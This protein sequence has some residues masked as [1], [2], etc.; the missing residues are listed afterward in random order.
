MPVLAF[1]FGVVLYLALAAARAFVIFVAVPLL[2]VGID[3]GFGQAF[4]AV[5]IADA[6]FFRTS[7][8]SSAKES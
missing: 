6:L 7:T 3:L 8:G 5:I 4:L 2:G 1:L